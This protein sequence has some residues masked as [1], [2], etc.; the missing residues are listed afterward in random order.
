MVETVVIAAATRGRDAMFRQLLV[1]LSQLV[2]PEEAE[3]VFVF[4]QNDAGFTIEPEVAAFARQGGR[5][6]R[7]VHEPRLGIPVARNAAIAA[8]LEEGADWLAFL[9]DDERAPPDWIAELVEGA[10]AGGFD[11]CGGPVDPVRPRGALSPAQEAVF[12]HFEARARLRQAARARGRVSGLPTSNWLCRAQVLQG[13]LRFDEALRFTGGSDTD[14]SD[15]C[16]ARG[17]RLGWVERA[18]LSEVIPAD[19]LTAAYIYRRARSQTLAKYAIRFRKTGRRGIGKAVFHAATQSVGG[20]LRAL[21]W[22]LAR[23]SGGLDGVRALG[24][25]AGWAQ[26][27]LGGTSRLYEEV[28]GE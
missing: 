10:R 14:F 9:D 2:P 19:K 8:A 23:R 22:V 1:G 5:R 15:R 24:V 21:P 26:G 25:A 17:L 11:L 6:A 18:R 4:V 7:A 20:A 27:A 13:G 16:A 12:A 3:L 28:I